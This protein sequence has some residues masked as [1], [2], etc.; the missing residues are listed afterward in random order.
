M[1]CGTPGSCP[2]GGMGEGGNFLEDDM[3][4]VIIGTHGTKLISAE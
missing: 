4:F 2:P 3:F 1:G